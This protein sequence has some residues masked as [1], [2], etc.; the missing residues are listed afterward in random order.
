MKQYAASA[1][2]FDHRAIRDRASDLT[3]QH[4]TQDALCDLPIVPSPPSIVIAVA[5]MLP[6]AQHPN[7]P[8][9]SNKLLQFRKL[10]TNRPRP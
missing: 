10:Y 9:Q 3:D 5:S 4:D 6:L 2:P 8:S 7:I 1:M